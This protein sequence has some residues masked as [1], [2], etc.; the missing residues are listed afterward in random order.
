M[1]KNLLTIFTLSTVLASVLV[2]SGCSFNL[3]KKVS[4][5]TKAEYNFTVTSMEQNLGEFV[6]GTFQQTPSNDFKC[7]DYNPGGKSDVQHYLMKVPLMTVPVDMSSYVGDL[8]TDSLSVKQKIEI[9]SISF[10][11]S[12]NLDVS[13]L[14]KNLNGMVKFGGPFVSQEN[15]LNPE[16]PLSMKVTGV[17][18]T[19][20][21][22]KYFEYETGTLDIYIEN[23]NG[24]DPYVVFSSKDSF[25]GDP[26]AKASFKR[27]SQSES[28][29]IKISGI[30]YSINAN[31]KASIN[32]AGRRVGMEDMILV[33]NDCDT[34]N[35]K[36]FYGEV[37]ENSKIKKTSGLN[38]ESEEQILT[39]QKV[40]LNLSSDVKNVEISK[41][42]LTTKIDV[43]PTW[44]GAK[45]DFSYSVSSG[46]EN[47]LKDEKSE[48]VVIENKV[49]TNEPLSVSP[50]VKVKIVNGDIVFSDQIKLSVDCKVEEVKS[51]TIDAVKM[52]LKENLSFAEIEFPKDVS[53]M[54]K[55][56]W[57]G[58][59]EFIVK[60][61]NTLP[62]GND[63]QVE[64]DSKFLNIKDS[65]TLK[66]GSGAEKTIIKGTADDISKPGKSTAGAKIDFNPTV[67]L[68][69]ENA[70][71]SITLKN[72][73]PGKE[74]EISLVVQP[75]IKWQQ[76]KFDASSIPQKLSSPESGMDSGINLSSFGDGSDQITKEILS[77]MKMKS[78][79][80]YL[81]CKNPGIEAFKNISIQG[82]I[83]MTNGNEQDTVV[84]LP[85]A[86]GNK[87][88]KFVDSLPNIPFDQ[89]E[90]VV[91]E[92]TKEK[93][94]AYADCASLFSLDA[95][96]TIKVY[97]DIEIT[98]ASNDSEILIKSSDL[99]ENANLEIDAFIDFP[100]SLIVTDDVS[101]KLLDL[102]GMESKE[103][104]SQNEEDWS[105]DLLGRSGPMDISEYKEYIN[106]IDHISF[107][108]F[109]KKFPTAYVNSEKE[110]Q[111]ILDLDPSSTNSK[112]K[113]P[114]SDVDFVITPET[115]YNILEKPFTPQ[116][117]L[118]YP[119][120]EIYIKRNI[121]VSLK[122]DCQIATDGTITIM[123]K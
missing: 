100:L 78:L 73:V 20:G 18:S 47:W 10:Q 92:L 29:K 17:Q 3:P 36:L 93:A 70:D 5:K 27:L 45:L 104:S 8:T 12:T 103:T 40:S 55:E 98:G 69:G 39:P 94:S 76:I 60:S 120:G 96:D 15:P 43:P 26:F 48:S 89:T 14:T 85:D 61:E 7:Y 25:A 71:G 31:Y 90:V 99:T 68:P 115:V 49:L 52:N 86:N 62:A 30:E 91:D 75:E 87:K 114:L 37:S 79:P 81:Y 28:K 97:Y 32:L 50:K 63:I 34:K 88:L 56:I 33:F 1:K 22:F 4:L 118:E 119:K 51:V 109:A 6:L 13:E 107:H 101:L 16:N 44:K 64:I 24:K 110:P 117:E 42:K 35:R 74:Y 54:V 57:F 11:Q 46:K 66:S 95:K 105:K 77:K 23:I 58:N 9:P 102:F 21:S 38:Y 83:K 106:A 41:A 111:L 53:D 80:V 116:I 67:K 19:E 2:M 82:N 123:G 108:I 84:L 72:I 65:L 121:D 59:S 122:V 113:Y 112:Q